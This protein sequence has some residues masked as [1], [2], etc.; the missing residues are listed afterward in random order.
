VEILE[1]LLTLIVAGYAFSAAPR[2]RAGLRWAVVAALVVAGLSLSILLWARRD[3][4]IRFPT[5]ATLLHPWLVAFYLALATIVVLGIL[6]GLI[7]R[8]IHRQWRRKHAC[9]NLFPKQRRR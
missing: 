5:T 8:S 2:F 1:L 3:Y 4:M 7:V 6:L 9:I